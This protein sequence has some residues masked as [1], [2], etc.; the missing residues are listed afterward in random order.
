MGKGLTL[1]AFCR[2][3]CNAVKQ[4]IRDIY[5]PWAEQNFFIK[6]LHFKSM[7]VIIFA[8]EILLPRCSA[9]GS[10]P[11]LGA[12]GREFESRHFDH[13]AAGEMTLAVIFYVMNKPPIS[14]VYLLSHSVFQALNKFSYRSDAVLAVLFDY[15][16]NSAANDG[17]VAVGAHLA[18]LFGV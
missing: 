3:H 9:A 17:P 11:A 2:E 14:A 18:G 12:G 7:C 6:P 13:V 4:I 5:R 15:L 8:Y 16:H 1:S 10:V